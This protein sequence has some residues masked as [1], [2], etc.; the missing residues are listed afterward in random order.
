[1]SIHLHNIVLLEFQA[2]PAGHWSQCHLMLQELQ[3]ALEDQFLQ[4]HHHL[5]SVLADQEGQC[6]QEDLDLPCLPL[7][8]HRHEDLVAQLV[9][10]I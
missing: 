10:N 6:V 4:E 2:L 9:P 7:A 5:L 3:G 8:P 1:M